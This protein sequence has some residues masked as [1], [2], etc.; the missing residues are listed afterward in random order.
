MTTLEDNLKDGGIEETLRVKDGDNSMIAGEGRKE[1]VTVLVVV[2][3]IDSDSEE[4]DS[5]SKLPAGTY[6]PGWV[7][8]NLNVYTCFY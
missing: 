8:G 7:G 6:L 3:G 1:V 4:L 5:E 2:K